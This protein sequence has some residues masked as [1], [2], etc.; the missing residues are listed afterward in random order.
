[1]KT[2]D[3]SEYGDSYTYDAQGRVLSIVSHAWDSSRSEKIYSYGETGSLLKIVDTRGELTTFDY[4]QA[5]RK[6]ETRILKRTDERAGAKATGID[7]MFADIDGAVLLDYCFG[8]N[9]SS[10]KTSYDHQDQPVETQGYDAAGSLL[11]RL[12]RTFDEQ[13]RITA[14]REITDNPMSMFPAKEVA[15][16]MANSGA[17]PDEVRAEM[18]KAMKVFGNESSKSYCYD[19]NGQVTK[20]TV[21]GMMGTFTRTYIYN[22]YGDV[23]EKQ[24]DLARNKRMPMGV[25]FNVS[26]TG[27]V[28]PSKP[29]SEW[30]PEPDLGASQNVRYSYKYDDQGNWTEKTATYDQ[31][32]SFTTRRELT[33]N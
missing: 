11:G 16:M 21:D 30:P 25:P 23:I 32:P 6:T 8:G 14:V 17:L 19:A 22:E 10:F 26:E 7:L 33:Y 12:V 24:T 29:P 1:M 5:G 20:A 27:E 4:D 9:A 18:S 2:S 15:Q 13:R 3:G 31:Q 28:I